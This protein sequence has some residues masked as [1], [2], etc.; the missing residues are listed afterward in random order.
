[1]STGA[2][3]AP[4]NTTQQQL[5]ELVEVTCLPYVQRAV[6]KVQGLYMEQVRYVVERAPRTALLV[7]HEKS[8]QQTVR[9]PRLG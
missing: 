8:S 3:V 4:R 5:D 7:D 2:L 1:M 9:V 6:V